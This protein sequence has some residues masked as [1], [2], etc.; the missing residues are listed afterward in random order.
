M[1]FLK[2][3]KD[4]LLYG[5]QDSLMDL[6]DE[7]ITTVLELQNNGIEYAKNKIKESKV[8]KTSTYWLMLSC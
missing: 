2:T 1:N 4:K 5:L 7:D 3:I 6:I 8:L